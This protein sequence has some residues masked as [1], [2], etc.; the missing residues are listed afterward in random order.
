MGVRLSFQVRRSSAPAHQLHDSN[1]GFHILV[2]QCHFPDT[3]PKQ[4]VKSQG[5]E[6]QRINLRC[7][8]WAQRSCTQVQ[9]QTRRL[10]LSLQV[11]P[12][13]QECKLSSPS[14][15]RKNK[16]KYCPCTASALQ[17]RHQWYQISTTSIKLCLSACTRPGAAFCAVLKVPWSHKLHRIIFLSEAIVPQLFR[18]TWTE[19]VLPGE[20]TQKLSKDFSIASN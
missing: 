12:Y 17:S 14:R 7:W 2:Q 15:K 11:E 3:I 6:K 18:F 5:H 10:T 4:N 13:N 9:C 19:E 20:D 1:V 16:R 8:R